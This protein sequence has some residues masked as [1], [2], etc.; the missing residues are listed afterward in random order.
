MSI[1]QSLNQAL[2]QAGIMKGIY[3]QTEKGKA[4]QKMKGLQKREKIVQN[5]LD[6][7]ESAV[8]PEASEADPVYTQAF[9]EQTDIARQ[10][11]ELNPNEKS[12]KEYAELQSAY[13][14]W[15]NA[16]K[17]SQEKRQQTLADQKEAFEMRRK[18]LEGTAEVPTNRT[19]IM[20]V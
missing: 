17:Y 7:A 8:K 14:D 6:I 10:K 13:E 5:Q 11:W 18:L 16:L 4:A 3:A 12:F 19:K 9:K 2:Y 15:E 20:E 1:Q